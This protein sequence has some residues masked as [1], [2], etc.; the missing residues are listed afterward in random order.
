[1]AVS[2]RGSLLQDEQAKLN[3]RTAP[4][5]AADRVR[6]RVDARTHELRDYLT[7]HSGRPCAWVA[8]KHV[9]GVVAV[10]GGLEIFVDDPTSY[11]EGT[12]VRVTSTG[13][14]AYGVV[15]S[16]DPQG[17]E[18]TIEGVP[19][20]ASD[21]GA[22]IEAEC[23]HPININTASAVVIAACLEGLAL[24][25]KI[26][27]DQITRT[28]ADGLAAAMIKVKFPDMDEFTKFLSEQRGLNVISQNDEA[29]IFVNFTNPNS[30][31]SPAPAPSRSC[32]VLRLRH[33]RRPRRPGPA[34]RRHRRPVRPPPDRR[35]RPSGTLAGAAQPVRLRTHAPPPLGSRVI[36]WPAC[37]AAREAPSSHARGRP[38]PPP[39]VATGASWKIVN[40]FDPGTTAARWRKAASTVRPDPPDRSGLDIE[41]FGD[42]AQDVEHAVHGDGRRERGVEQPIYMTYG[43]IRAGP[44]CSLIS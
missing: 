41:G 33:R 10:S 38:S 43:S 37:V 1:M 5:L 9:R 21:V 8:P 7:E 14:P 36:T 2:L 18:F 19:E 12:K 20:S 40:H 23:R 31:A 26:T 42:V 27:E 22:L 32:S 39:P 6:A 24:R 4:V 25:G 17:S 34:L 15:T 28:E 30:A 16:V 11:G 3:L 35:N 13:E 29:A 44:T